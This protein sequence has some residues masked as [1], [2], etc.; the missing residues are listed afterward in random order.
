MPGGAD[1]TSGHEHPPAPEII[2]AQ[3]LV[4]AGHRIQAGQLAHGDQ[5]ERH[6]ETLIGRPAGHGPVTAGSAALVVT[7]ER[8]A[9]AIDVDAVD[10]A[11]DPDAIRPVAELQ[12]GQRRALRGLEAEA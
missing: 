1:L 8:M 9:A 2:A 12:R 10:H 7:D 5:I 6:L 3:L 4:E 11:S